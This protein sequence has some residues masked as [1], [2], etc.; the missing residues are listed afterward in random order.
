MNTQ[1]AP[2]TLSMHADGN[3]FCDKLKEAWIKNTGE[4]DPILEFL[5]NKKK[6][7]TGMIIACVGIML[8]AI[9]GIILHSN[10]NNRWLGLT[11]L[12]FGFITFVIGGMQCPGGSENKSYYRYNPAFIRFVNTIGFEHFESLKAIGPTYGYKALVIFIEERLCEKAFQILRLEKEGR[13][14]DAEQKRS[15]FKTMH[16]NFLPFGVVDEKWD[17]YFANAKADLD[18]G[19]CTIVGQAVS[20]KG[21]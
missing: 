19:E 6:M 16:G 13:W 10:E 8:I 17:K 9:P 14:S 18:S 21:S 11:L 2:T 7:C 3:L 5:N 15:E 1:N 12:L 20:P 4:R